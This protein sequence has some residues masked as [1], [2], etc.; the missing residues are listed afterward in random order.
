MAWASRG[1][2]S[3]PRYEL[4][5]EY[6]PPRDDGRPEGRPAGNR[7]LSPLSPAD[8]AR[9]ARQPAPRGR[10][11]HGHLRARP[12]S[13]DGDGHAGGFRPEA[14]LRGPRG[15]APALRRMGS[16]DEVLPAGAARG[17]GG[18]A[19]DADGERLP[20]RAPR[21]ES[22]GQAPAYGPAAPGPMTP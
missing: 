3:F 12:P 7:R 8:L 18:S 21:D 2:K 22:A 10:P 5:L 15:I 6:D 19:L 9:G 16:V 13:A 1:R 11:A 17:P 4:L 14:Q 20:S